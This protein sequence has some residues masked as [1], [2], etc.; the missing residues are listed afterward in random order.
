MRK[1]LN[2]HY[3]ILI[4]LL[5]LIRQEGHSQNQLIKIKEWSTPE[6][7]SL[8]IDRIGDFFL[9]HKKGGITKYDPDGNMV[10][11]LPKKKPTLIEPWYHPSIFIYE[12]KTQKYFSFGRYFENV[13]EHNLAPE[14]AIE[15]WL[16]CP[17]HDNRLWI[18][19]RADYSLKKVNPLSH[20][21]I[22]EF[23]LHTESST[24]EFTDLK[25]YQNLLF[26]QE[27]NG[28]IWIVNTLGNLI[29][30]IEM[31]NPGNFSFFG[32][33]LYYLENNTIKFFNLLTE[34]REEI[35]LT[36]EMKFALVTDERIL[37]VS[38]S[39]QVSLYNF[40]PQN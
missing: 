25:E 36:G 5:F 12:R 30:K 6:I 39:N 16:V 38:T 17:T 18:L 33:Q 20:E 13:Q 24:P 15:P 14:F 35:P 23:K 10:A 31:E 19:D 40:T 27:K 9:I 37:T 4:G 8:S 7:T 28:G 1:Y 21:V 3:L 32:Q 34:E 11:S 22:N 29:T 26:L 2:L